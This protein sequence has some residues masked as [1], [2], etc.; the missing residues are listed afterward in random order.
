MDENLFNC[1]LT[2][3]EHFGEL[4]KKKNKTEYNAIEAITKDVSKSLGKIEIAL[5]KA[6]QYS[7]RDGTKTEWG[8]HRRGML[9]MHEEKLGSRFE[10]FN[11]NKKE[12][13][14]KKSTIE[15]IEKGLGKIPGL[16][17]KVKNSMLG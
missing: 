10:K 6:K 2:E 15:K 3:V 16:L 1:C 17:W 5:F 12:P 13:A 4:L 9:A 8:K 11:F 14:V 7:T